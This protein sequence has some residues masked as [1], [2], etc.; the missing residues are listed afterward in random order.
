MTKRVV[1]V[2]GLILL[3]LILGGGYLF[4]QK[5]RVGANPSDTTAQVIQPAYFQFTDGTNK[6]IIKLNDQYKIAEA[7]AII[8]D[9]LDKII[10]GTIVKTPAS[11]NPPWS[12]HLDP[13][14]ISFYQVGRET[15]D[16]SIQDIED[17]LAEVGDSLL[18]GLRWCPWGSK[19]IA[20]V[21][22]DNPGDL[23]RDR[24]VNEFDL[25]LVMTRW[26]QSAPDLYLGGESIVNEAVLSQVLSNW[27]HQY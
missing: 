10:V 26:Q 6:F 21:L 3:L 24:L 13:S 1:L 14:T 2:I 5:N 18:P 19:L 20:E 8:K 17:H 7:R 27:R 15:C 12:Y 25:S 22:I 16:A 11:Y 4:W 23:N 9:N